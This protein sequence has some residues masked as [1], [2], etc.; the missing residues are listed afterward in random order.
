MSLANVLS[1]FYMDGMRPIR[2]ANALLRITLAVVFGF[3]SLAH[4]PVMGF[5]KAHVGSQHHHMATGT[6]THGHDQ[7]MPSRPDTAAVCYSFGCFVAVAP[8]AI[9]APRAGFALLAKLSPAR[10]PAVVPIWPDQPD[11]PPRLQA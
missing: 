3:M 10:A 4:G 9:A 7:S 5:A 8:V 6:H 11:P 1:P 2:P